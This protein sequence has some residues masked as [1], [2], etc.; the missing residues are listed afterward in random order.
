MA[1][2]AQLV[3]RSYLGDLLGL[4]EH[5]AGCIPM[6]L[7]KAQLGKPSEG[8]TLI[9]QSI[10]ARTESGSRADIT[11]SLT[12]LAEAQA[13]DGAIDDA[14]GTLDDALRANSEEP[15]FQPNIITLRGK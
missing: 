6:G 9:R 8:F 12:V 11:N 7:G 5:F 1:H 10:A 13:L 3:T 15:V 2:H 4:E 14:L